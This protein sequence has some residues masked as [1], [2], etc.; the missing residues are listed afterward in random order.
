MPS[1]QL[2]PTPTLP[3]LLLQLPR[4]PACVASRVMAHMFWRKA[5]LSMQPASRR[6]ASLTYSGDDAAD[7]MRSPREF[8]DANMLIGAAQRTDH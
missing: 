3:T 8:G 7:A 5:V 2:P 4:A 6:M 1:L